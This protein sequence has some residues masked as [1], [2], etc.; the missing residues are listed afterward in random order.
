MKSTLFLVNIVLTTKVKKLQEEIEDLK[1]KIRKY[2]AQTMGNISL[3][4]AGDTIKKKRKRKTKD[5]VERN[6][7]CNIDNCT[8]SY[9][10]ENSL[11]QHMKLKH[12]EF[13][14]RIKEKEQS[15]AKS[16][17]SKDPKKN[18]VSGSVADKRDYNEF[19]APANPEIDNT[20]KQVVIT[21]TKDLSS[22][23]VKVEVPNHGGKSNGA[24]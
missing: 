13:W 24:V 11:N 6:F 10:S 5:Q 16:T 22:Q 23:Q 7:S 17:T 2:E 18:S 1:E 14:M 21:H 20:M 4:G 8:K 12:T 19:L 3:G 9:G 15:L